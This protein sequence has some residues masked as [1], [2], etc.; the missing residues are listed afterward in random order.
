MLGML[1]TMSDLNGK[2]MAP[3]CDFTRTSQDDTICMC[4]RFH[5][6][7][8]LLQSLEGESIHRATCNYGI[9]NFVIWNNVN[10]RSLWMPKFS[11]SVVACCTGVETT[12]MPCE[13]KTRPIFC[14]AF[15]HLLDP[16]MES[17]LHRLCRHSNDDRE[18]LFGLPKS[19]FGRHKLDIIYLCSPCYVFC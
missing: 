13:Q 8:T 6:G 11:D 7:K 4:L 10:T 19:S 9:C 14:S 15:Q 5:V 12:K 16:C 17:N 1:S 18:C 2:N 3:S